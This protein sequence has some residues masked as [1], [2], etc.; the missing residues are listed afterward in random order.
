MSISLLC[1]NC[2]AAI[3]DGARFCQACGR[4]TDG[5]P[6]PPPALLPA[7]AQGV[8]PFA[9]PTPPPAPVAYFH[10][11]TASY[12]HLAAATRSYTTP[13]VI[14][15]IL[16]LVFWLPGLIANLVYLS[17]A[18]EDRHLSGVE[19]QGRGCLVALV[20]VFGILPFLLIGGFFVLPLLLVAAVGALH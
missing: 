2:G 10:P 7:V 3:G 6:P 15:M 1:G 8:A 12:A 11:P 16:Y 13:A 19:P 9:Y 17:S 20:V 4:A 14:T 18:N 5:T